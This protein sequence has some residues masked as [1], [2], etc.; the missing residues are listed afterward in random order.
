MNLTLEGF[1]SNSDS[2]IQSITFNQDYSSIAIGTK[3]GY[4][5]YAFKDSI[6]QIS[7]TFV[8][9]EH[10]NV[11]IVERFYKSSLLAIVSLQSARKLRLYNLKKKTEIN[12]INYINSIL[13]VKLNRKRLVVCLQDQIYIHSLKNDIQQLWVIKNIPVNPKGL[14][15]L[16]PCEN[17]CLLAYPAS[18]K[19]GEVQIFD[20]K[21]LRNI[22]LIA[23]HENPL[24]ALAFNNTG[25]LL[26]SASDRGTIIRVHDVDSGLCHYEF[27][28]SYTTG[29]EIYSL[30]FSSDSLYLAASGSTGT[31]HVF[32]LDKSK[33]QQETEEVRAAASSSTLGGYLGSALI[34]ASSYFSNYFNEWLSFA[35]CRLPFE[36][37]KNVCAIVSIDK[38]LRVLVV[39]SEG[40]LYIYNLNETDGGDCTLVKQYRLG[41]V[42]CDYANQSDLV[43]ENRY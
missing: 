11:C 18:Q 36:G 19:T 13:T 7:K 33:D 3:T 20:A 28:R 16:S 40:Y 27:R 37:L 34:Q 5:L 23:A 35:T 15:A 26:A 22:N 32:K 42:P 41:E 2:N 9:N 21:E 1:Q 10:K 29:A 38:Q 31:V 14:C 30:A 25:T 39:S 24:F 8:D 6:D 4:E 17:R 43:D 12:I